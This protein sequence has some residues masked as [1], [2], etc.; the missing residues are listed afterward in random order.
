MAFNPGL[1]ST[2]NITAAAAVSKGEIGIDDAAKNFNSVGKNIGDFL[3]KFSMWAATSLAAVSTGSF[4]LAYD[5][6]RG[7][8]PLFTVAA[9][10]FDEF[11]GQTPQPDLRSIL[12]QKQ[13]EF[14][15]MSAPRRSIT[16]WVSGVALPL[17][18][19]FAGLM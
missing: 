12:K 18:N 1:V 8:E 11:L 15:T 6:S 14:P 5:A 17:A 7:N 4:L 19:A 16:N 3:G 10:K 2:G 9:Q 13:L